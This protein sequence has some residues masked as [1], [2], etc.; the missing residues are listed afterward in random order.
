[1]KMLTLTRKPSPGRLVV[2]GDDG[3]GTDLNRR[4][5]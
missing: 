4:F 1:M 3:L 2:D 5:S